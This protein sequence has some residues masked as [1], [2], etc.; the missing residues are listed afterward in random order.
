MIISYLH[1]RGKT[2]GLAD[3]WIVTVYHGAPH[4]G[5]IHKLYYRQQHIN[6][7]T[8][9]CWE[10]YTSLRKQGQDSNEEQQFSFHGCQNAW[11]NS[12]A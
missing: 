5:S 11:N 8:S 6:A 1:K 12:G 10:E 9:E 3:E 7:G 2:G 4:L